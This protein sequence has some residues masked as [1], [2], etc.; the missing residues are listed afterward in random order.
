MAELGQLAHELYTH[1]EN[2]LARGD[3]GNFG[4]EPGNSFRLGSW[5]SISGGAKHSDIF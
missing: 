4:E 2:L 5:Y 3:V 1:L